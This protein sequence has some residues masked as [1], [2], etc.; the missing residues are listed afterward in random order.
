[1][2]RAG[3]KVGGAGAQLVGGDGGDP[4]PVV[5]TCAEP[6]DDFFDNH[7]SVDCRPFCFGNRR[8]M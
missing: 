8:V 1:V 5:A 3:R 2:Q 7:H 6:F 4:H